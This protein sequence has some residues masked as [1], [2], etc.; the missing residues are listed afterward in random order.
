MGGRTQKPLPVST[1]K[2]KV[3]PIIVKRRYAGPA[4]IYPS[5]MKI[6]VN[7]KWNTNNW[8]EN[9]FLAAGVGAGL[10]TQGFRPRN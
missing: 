6:K 9:A 5:R 3:R 7:P 4:S 1:G 2:P 8:W 10:L